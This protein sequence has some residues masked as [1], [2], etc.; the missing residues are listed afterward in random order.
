[1]FTDLELICKKCRRKFWLTGAEQAAYRKKRRALPNRCDACRTTNKSAEVSRALATIE[2]VRA[3]AN[4]TLGDLL[5]DP[6]VL[7]QDILQLVADSAAPIQLRRRTFTEWLRG[8][9]LYA[10]QVEQKL[11]AGNAADQLLRQRLDLIR[12][13][14]AVARLRYEAAQ[15]QMAQHQSLLRARLE[16]LELEEKIVQLEALKEKRIETLQLEEAGRQ[17]QL[18]AQF[19][20]EPKKKS[21]VK[22]AINE[23]RQVFRAKASAK[24][25][26]LSDFVQELQ[27]VYRANVEDSE[28]A[29]RIRAV[30]EAY[31]Q[32]TEALPRD[33]REFLERVEGAEDAGRD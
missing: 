25:L 5:P 7:F 22:Q 31:K 19:Q 20:P 23:H 27:K 9:D 3:G 16:Q 15:A 29:A 30:L 26:V 14:Q 33:V 4:N 11:R 17:A 8:L 32:E 6:T 10:I 21:L 18:L 2:Q 13:L 24:Q 28:K 1:M 12:Q